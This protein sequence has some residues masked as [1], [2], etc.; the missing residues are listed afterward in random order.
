MDLPLASSLSSIFCYYYYTPPLYLRT[1]SD[2][3]RSRSIDKIDSR[4]VVAW[5]GFS[6][7]HVG[8]TA[9][10]FLSFARLPVLPIAH[11]LPERMGGRANKR[12]GAKIMVTL[13]LGRRKKVFPDIRSCIDRMFKDIGD[14]LYLIFD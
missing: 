14:C 9:R 5:C 3:S 11:D 2:P 12:S 8:G 4:R 10:P 7:P 6:Q 1:R 13:T